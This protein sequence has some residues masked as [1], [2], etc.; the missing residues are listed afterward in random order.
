[1]S[2]TEMIDSSVKVLMLHCI[3]IWKYQGRLH[4]NITL[5]MHPLRAFVLQD[6]KSIALE[7]VVA[8]N[9]I[10]TLYMEGWGELISF[11]LSSSLVYFSTPA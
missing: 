1:M 2:D 7:V 4:Q 10:S 11:R 9:I 6:F 5:G 3:T 8:V